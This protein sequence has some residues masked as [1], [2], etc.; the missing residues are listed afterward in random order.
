[1]LARRSG[2]L[3]FSLLELMIAAALVAILATLAY[4]AYQDALAK[5]KR[6]QARTALFTLLQQQERYMTQFNTYVPFAA[7]SSPGS[8]KT[9]KDHSALD[10][11]RAMSSNHQLGAQAC[12]ASG[13]T[14]PPVTDCI[15][16]FAV[17]RAGVFDDQAATLIAIDSLNRKSCVPVDSKACWP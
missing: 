15:E 12:K 16:V 14:T 6:V 2:C 9:F 1:M 17:P 13:A 10:E 11:S 4:P 3:G 8:P 5:S 7:G